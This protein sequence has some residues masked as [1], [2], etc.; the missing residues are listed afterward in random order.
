MTDPQRE[1]TPSLQLPDGCG[2]VYVMGIL[3][4]VRTF[5]PQRWDHPPA[6]AK[7]LLLH[8][9]LHAVDRVLSNGR[10]GGEILEHCRQN[11]K[12]GYQSHF[13]ITEAY[14]RAWSAGLYATLSDP[15][16]RR[17]VG[18]MLTQ[19]NPNG[20]RPTLPSD[21]HRELAEELGLAYPLMVRTETPTDKPPG[22]LGMA[23]PVPEVAHR[24]IRDTA[25]EW[26]E[27]HRRE[28]VKDCGAYYVR[29]DTI[30]DVDIENP[31]PLIA[32]R[33][34][35][36]PATDRASALLAAVRLVKGGG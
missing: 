14:I 20:P 28:V 21:P 34:E 19:E 10:L 35:R 25:A 15:R 1:R 22:L 31:E 27:D 8:E 24:I 9:I 6:V 7:E 11:L 16:N 3:F 30:G 26:L 36:L 33:F 23:Y 2:W 18:W 32:V 12:D 29:G 4:S 5:D 13:T 17:L